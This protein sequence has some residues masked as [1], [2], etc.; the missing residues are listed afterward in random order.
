MEVKN[1]NIGSLTT[2]TNNVRT[3]E[4]DG[5]ETIEML[6]VINK[7]DKLVA[8]AVEKEIPQITKAV[9]NIARALKQGGRLIYFGAG[10]SG[11]LGVLDASECPPTFGTDKEMIQGFIAGGDYALRNPVEGAEDD[12]NAGSKIVETINV[13]KKDVI[14]GIT[15]S[16]RTQYVLGAIAAA[17][18]KG[19]YTVGICNNVE[20]ELHKACKVTIAPIV[21]PEV[22]Q[23]STRL[24]AGTAQKL[25]LNMLTTGA[26]IKIGKVYKNYMVDMKASNEK[27]LDR[28]VRLVIA[29]T[30]VSY[31]KALE[32]LEKCDFHVKTAIVMI[33][34]NCDVDKAKRLLTLADGYVARAVEK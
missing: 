12:Y 20:T 33:N 2:E 34:A 29:T 28:A 18:Q 17:N 8:E 16:G 4:I 3:R 14:V 25:V 24:K 30:D 7:E 19:C 23:G 31:E 6:Q 5:L 26:M 1:L 27:L 10:T 22:I 21:G 13:T 15:A 11:R 9:D 32:T